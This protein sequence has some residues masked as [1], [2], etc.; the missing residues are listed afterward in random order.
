M[1]Q[2]DDTQR[3]NARPWGQCEKWELMRYMTMQLHKGDYPEHQPINVELLTQRAQFNDPASFGTWVNPNK[4]PKTKD[5]GRGT[6]QSQ[7]LDYCKSLAEICKVDGNERVIGNILK[8]MARPRVFTALL[9]L[10]R[11]NDL[12]SLV[13]PQT[14]GS[15]RVRV[16]KT[17]K[18]ARRLHT[19]V[20]MHSCSGV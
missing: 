7:W 3:E 16:P 1:S 2:K 18:V 6:N 12:G 19:V 13:A 9:D 15:K 5:T 20:F 17:H 4:L 8:L 11:H 10:M 14:D